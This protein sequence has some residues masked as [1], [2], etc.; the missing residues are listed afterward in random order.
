M[1]S[2][3]ACHPSCISS[4]GFS[5]YNNHDDDDDD[6]DYDDGDDEPDLLMN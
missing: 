3:D 1:Q 4:D 2:D 6:D 5:S